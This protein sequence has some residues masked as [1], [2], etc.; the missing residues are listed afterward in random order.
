MEFYA[1]HA[2]KYLEF[3]GPDYV[4]LVAAEYVEYR[5]RRMRSS[6]LR[7]MRSSRLKSAWSS[8]LRSLRSLRLYEKFEE[9]VELKD[10]AIV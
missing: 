6:R 3:E 5:L 1:Q 4:G 7:S 8:R 2:D 10:G 9:Y